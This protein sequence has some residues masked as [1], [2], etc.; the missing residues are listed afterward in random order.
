M[1]E[2][3]DFESVCRLLKE[4][5]YQTPNSII[6]LLLTTCTNKQRNSKTKRM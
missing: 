6:Y 5:H 4:C 2:A 3:K 1:S